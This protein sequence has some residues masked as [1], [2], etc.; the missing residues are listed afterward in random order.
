QT[1]NALE[2]TAGFDTYQWYLDGA[3]LT[4]ETNA[5]ISPSASGDYTVEVSEGACSETSAAYN[6]TMVGIQESA[7]RSVRIYPNPTNSLVYLDLNE[8]EGTA[9]V[10]V[11]DMSGRVVFNG[12]RNANAGQFQIDLSNVVRGAY[13]VEVRGKD[14]FATRSRLIKN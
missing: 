14:G 10:I 13:T 11:Y 2:A 8:F 5:S 12:Q 3:E 4:G 1:G 6:Y 7:N 9:T